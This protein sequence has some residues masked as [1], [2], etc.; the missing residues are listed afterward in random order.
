MA[1]LGVG[2]KELARRN[3]AAWR[4]MSGSGQP[5][6]SVAG[7]SQDRRPLSRALPKFSMFS[8]A[9]LNASAVTGPLQMRAAAWTTDTK[10]T[11]RLPSP[12]NDGDCRLCG[13]AR[14]LR[15]ESRFNF[16]LN[17]ISPQ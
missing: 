2:L 1:Q 13:H 17:K 7:S 5:I 14:L 16:P 11:R 9:A 15:Q 6:S 4:L 10:Q 12:S 8:I 3:E